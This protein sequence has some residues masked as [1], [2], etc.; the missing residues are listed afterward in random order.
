MKSNI[1]LYLTIL[2]LFS[3]YLLT[4]QK[5]LDDPE[6]LIIEEDDEDLA[7][8]ENDDEE[9]DETKNKKTEDLTDEVFDKLD[10]YRLRS[11]EEL[12]YITEM[13]DMVLLQFYYVPYSTKSKQLAVELKKINK[14]I[15]NI[16]AIIAINCDEF[17][18]VDY[19]HCQKNAYSTD[20]FPKIRLFVPQEKRFDIEKNEIK[21]HYD[22]PFT[23]EE[24]NEK[25]IYDF[26][27]NHIPNKAVNLDDYSIQS[28]LRT[29]TM[30]KVILFTK[31]EVPSL[32]FKGLSN[33]L[34]D[35]LLFGYVHESEKSIV[36]RFNVKTFPSLMIYKNFD[37][38][39]LLDEPI[40]KFYSGSLNNI[41]KIK[42][43][44]SK[45]TLSE[46]KYISIKRG[47]PEETGEDIARNVDFREI[48]DSN[49]I[50]YFKKFN[51]NNRIMV[52]F[53]TKNK[54][55]LSVKKYLIEGHGFF[56]NVYF[57]CKNKEVCLN[58]FGVKNF[59]SL[60][61][62]EAGAFNAESST[63]DS[64]SFSF[65]PSTNSTYIEDFET[66]IAAKSN[67]KVENEASFP[68]TR[69]DVKDRRKF[70]LISVQNADQ[71]TVSITNIMKNRNLIN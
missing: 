69:G 60:R 13:V 2:L 5:D 66:Y 16:A 50:D 19:K 22:I 52:L 24:M 55:K 14:K 10:V 41:N 58:K 45:Y 43:F 63:F 46:K 57:N 67:I 36:D 39:E 44:L 6:D 32:I 49:Y 51:K 28:F 65:N 61:L 54:L 18:P 56:L 42:E 31:D 9:L 15:E 35:E 48:D 7:S 34:Y 70:M 26:I 59:P 38:N 17:T 23:G 68:Y 3:N 1:F 62:F 21:R 29:D 11:E 8:K 20:S 53:N 27:I 12:G 37:P 33:N 40:I 47:I 25:T 4:L 71:Q 64:N 30:N